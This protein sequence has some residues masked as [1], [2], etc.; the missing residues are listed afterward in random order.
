MQ[1]D[2]VTTDY[3]TVRDEAFLYDEYW[4]P[5]GGVEPNAGVGESCAIISGNSNGDR[6]CTEANSVDLLCET[7]Y[8]HEEEDTGIVLVIGNLHTR[9]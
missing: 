7:H 8:S 9:F 3:C 2:L 1:I 4:T 6:S 5:S